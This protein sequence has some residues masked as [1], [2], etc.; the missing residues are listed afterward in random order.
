MFEKFFPRKSGLRQGPA[1]SPRVKSYT[2]ECGHRFDYFHHSS[3]PSRD[4]S[5]TEFVFEIMLDGR[6]WQPLTILLPDSALEEWQRT[7]DRD[8]S[9]TERY[10]IAKMML[11]RILDCDCSPAQLPDTVS[12]D[13]ADVAVLLEKLDV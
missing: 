8:L 3:Q 4:L 6:S 12:V 2:A 9:S 7:N 1:A 13:A 11:F 10:A 5:G